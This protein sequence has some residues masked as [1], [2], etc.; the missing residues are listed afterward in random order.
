MPFGYSLIT[1]LVAGFVLAFVLGLI[2]NRLRLSPL[3][4]YI[5]AGVLVGPN[6]PGFVADVSLA[7]QLAEIGV[8]LLMFGVGLHFSLA[9]LMAVRRIA[10]P[11]LIG[12]AAKSPAGLGR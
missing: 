1:T 7:G 5:V 4:G 12:T 8:M 10:V 2:A 9:D 11:G 6:T 3:V